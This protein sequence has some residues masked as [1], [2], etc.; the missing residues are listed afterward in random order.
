MYVTPRAL[1]LGFGFRGYLRRTSNQGRGLQVLSPLV[2][3]RA[4]VYVSRI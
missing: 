1:A 3:I 4:T 2:L